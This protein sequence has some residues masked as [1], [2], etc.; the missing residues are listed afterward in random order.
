MY[1]VYVATEFTENT[2]KNNSVKLLLIAFLWVFL[3]KKIGIYI[4]EGVEVVN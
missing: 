3:K 2:I 1:S 4:S